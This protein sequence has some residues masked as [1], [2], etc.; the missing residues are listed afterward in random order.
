MNWVLFVHKIDEFNNNISGS[1][2]GFWLKKAK[3]YKPVF[4]MRNFQKSWTNMND[5]KK[6]AM[7]DISFK[8]S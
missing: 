1:K 7:V 5:F 8:T 2:M 4:M 6:I 3:D